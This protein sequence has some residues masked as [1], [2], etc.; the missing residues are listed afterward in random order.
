MGD[1]ALMGGGLGIF[2][3]T[4]GRMGSVNFMALWAYHVGSQGG[5]STGEALREKD[6]GVGSWNLGAVLEGARV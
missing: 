6:A 5:F 2:S 1:S 3:L 4:C